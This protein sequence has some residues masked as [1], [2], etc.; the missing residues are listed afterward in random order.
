MQN[1]CKVKEVYKAKK[2]KTPVSTLWLV[3][4][5]INS[6]TKKIV[7]ANKHCINTYVIS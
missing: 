6:I 3:Y 2:W 4:F 1:I 5:N 7:H